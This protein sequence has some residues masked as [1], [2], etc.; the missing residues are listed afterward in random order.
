MVSVT[1]VLERRK[2]DMR[3]MMNKQLLAL[4]AGCMFAGTVGVIAQESSN[5]SPGRAF[6]TG[7]TTAVA[8]RKLKVDNVI[9]RVHTYP[10]ENE[11]SIWGTPGYLYSAVSHTVNA[12]TVSDQGPSGP[13]VGFMSYLNDDNATAPAVAIL[14]DA[15][16][17]K[18][19]DVV[20]G[21]NFIARNDTD[22]DVAL[23]GVEIDM[24]PTAGTKIS[25]TSAGLILNT[26]NIS[27]AAPAIL[28]G[29]VSR[30]KWG[31][32]LMTAE[33]T[34]THFGVSTGNTTTSV[35]FL[36]TTNGRFSSA[37]IRLGTGAS[38]GIN[39]GGAPFGTSPYVYN[40]GA[41]NLNINAPLAVRISAPGGLTVNG[42]PVSPSATTSTATLTGCRTA[43]TTTAR[44][45]KVATE[46]TVHLDAQSCTSNAASF[47]L[48]GALPAGYTSARDTCYPVSIIDNGK[49][50]IGNVCAVAG[51]STLRFAVA[52]A[53]PAVGGG[54]T[55]SG[56]KGIGPITFTFTRQ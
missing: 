46:V 4:L 33:I 38:Q 24:Q 15:V 8:G 39:F 47:T 23:K 19:K 10:I 35:S 22:S 14:G 9:E 7:N 12:S 16:A 53:D 30:G 6:A 52:S 31:N 18:A 3:L 50:S 42:T 29:G 20:F 37:A 43:P 13:L 54:F 45:D 32:G 28:V 34:G 36:D 11:G 26:F 56:T 2:T 25:S 49:H 44:L 41:N 27:S 1:G 51:T 55:D 17:R 48:T 5:G 21:A 40:D